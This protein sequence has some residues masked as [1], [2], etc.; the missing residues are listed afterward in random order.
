MRLFFFFTF[1]LTCN[2]L[3]L[4]PFFE[5]IRIGG[6]GGST[7]TGNF[8]V[9]VGLA[10][11]TFFAIIVAGV[12]KHGFIGHWKN[13]IP[14]GVPDPVLFILIPRQL[15]IILRKISQSMSILKMIQKSL[16]TNNL[17]SFYP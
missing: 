5:F 17:Q 1:I 13:M 10:I 9:T 4:I 15:K 16:K 2:L 8:G 3:G 6:G 14:S 12:K 11:I 7:A